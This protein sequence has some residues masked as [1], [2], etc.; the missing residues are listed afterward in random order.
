VSCQQHS[1]DKERRTLLTET[2]H[3]GKKKKPQQLPLCLSPATVIHCE[4]EGGH[5]STAEREETLL[6]ERT[7]DRGRNQHSEA[8]RPP[9]QPPSATTAATAGTT[10][11]RPPPSQVRLPPPFFFFF[12]FLFLFFPAVHCMNS[13]RELIHAFCSCMNSGREL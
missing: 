7:K 13:R 11:A 1:H 10:P 8:E 3:T 2:T 9:L 5:T 12:F 6:T 4:Q